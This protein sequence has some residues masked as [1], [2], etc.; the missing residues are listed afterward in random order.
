MSITTNALKALL[1]NVLLALAIAAAAFVAVGGGWAVAKYTGILPLKKAKKALTI[2]NTPITVDHV[3]AIGELVTASYYDE[4][5][6]IMKQVPEVIKKGSSKGKDTTVVRIQRIPESK[7][8]GSKEMVIVQKAHARIG[9]DLTCLSQEDV[10]T[11]KTG[12]AVEV[13]LPDV[14][15]LDFIMNPSDTEVFLENGDWDLDDLKLSL[16]P[17]QDEIQ[18]KMN[19]DQTLI[20]KARKGAQEVVTQ[21]LQAAGYETVTVTFASARNAALQ[22]PPREQ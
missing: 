2:E 18:A 12:K 6:V 21:L 17:L 13:R 4:T 11:D 5:V 9:I 7:S 16:L 3:K 14:T 8:N 19:A 10:R 15:C 22:L 20:G 1:V